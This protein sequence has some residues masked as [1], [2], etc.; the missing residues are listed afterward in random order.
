MPY[1]ISAVESGRS[2]EVNTVY[3]YIKTNNIAVVVGQ[4]SSEIKKE[5][6]KRFGSTGEY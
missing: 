3:F 5:M 6:K 4:F 2:L 1:R